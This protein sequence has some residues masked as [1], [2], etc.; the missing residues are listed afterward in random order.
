MERAEPFH[1]TLV[2]ERKPVPITVSEKVAPV[3]V[4]EFG[5]MLVMPN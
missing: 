5:F 1:C 2:P 4:A 3:A